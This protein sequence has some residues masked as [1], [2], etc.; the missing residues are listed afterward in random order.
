VN[1]HLIQRS[2]SSNELNE[3]ASGPLGS[4]VGAS[5]NSA[6]IPLHVSSVMLATRP[7]AGIAR[8]SE[9]SFNMNV[10]RPLVSAAPAALNIVL[11]SN[12]VSAASDGR[13]HYFEDRP[14]AAVPLA[15]V[16]PVPQ[17]AVAPTG[18]RK[19]IKPPF[20]KSSSSFFSIIG[21]IVLS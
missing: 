14:H 4:A 20:R 3:V 21:M 18:K 11:R 2:S 12:R 10:D 19:F 8:Q 13:K 16:R 9:Q 17:Q 6:S 15:A 5:G 1:G 7:Q